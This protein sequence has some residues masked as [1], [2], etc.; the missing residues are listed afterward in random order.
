ME[1]QSRKSRFS[2][3]ARLHPCH[4]K[5][6][7]CE[8]LAP[9]NSWLNT[10]FRMNGYL[11]SQR[12]RAWRAIGRNDQHRRKSIES[13]TRG[14]LLTGCQGTEPRR[15][16]TGRKRR[17]RHRHLVR[18]HTTLEANGR[19]RRSCRNVAV[20]PRGMSGL[21]RQKRKRVRAGNGRSRDDQHQHCDHP[22][23]S[24]HSVYVPVI[25]MRSSSGSRCRI[26]SGKRS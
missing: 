1:A 3:R 8:A 25:L 17:I 16:S 9:R 22:R 15:Q 10:C 19:R 11:D 26:S 12:S 6:Q 2:G 21:R 13:E 18:A 20:A 23:G 14:E 5:S 4:Q 24:L 7:K